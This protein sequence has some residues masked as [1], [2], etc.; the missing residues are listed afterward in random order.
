MFELLHLCFF[1]VSLVEHQNLN[2]FWLLTTLIKYLEED[3]QDFGL[4]HTL[5]T[6]SVASV[7]PVTTN[8]VSFDINSRFD[9]SGNLDILPH[10]S[11]CV[12]LL[13]QSSF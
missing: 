9:W 8:S 12:S 6:L 4:K 5:S 1:S 10:V 3:K 7:R 13:R 2:Q 11:R